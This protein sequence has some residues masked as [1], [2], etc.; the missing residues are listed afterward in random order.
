QAEGSYYRAKMDLC[1]AFLAWGLDALKPGGQL[2]F[3]LPQYWMQRSSTQALR[4]QLLEAGRV[5][6]LWRFPEKTLFQHAP[7]Y[8]GSL[9][10]WQKAPA[11]DENRAAHALPELLAGEATHWQAL[12]SAALK[13]MRYWLDGQSGKLLLAEPET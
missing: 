12:Q 8:H 6:E 3:V 4:V 10:I 11:S 7:G 9:L 1:D 13:P 5:L 2:A